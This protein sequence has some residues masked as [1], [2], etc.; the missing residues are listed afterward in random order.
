MMKTRFAL[1]LLTLSLVAFLALAPSRP[2]AAA[3]LAPGAGVLQA[4]APDVTVEVRRKH[5]SFR[6][7]RHGRRWHGL[8]G[9]PYRGRGIVAGRSP[10]GCYYNEGGGRYVSCSA[11]GFR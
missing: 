8:F 10:Y 7:Y 11:G 9:R 5:R 3:P 6:H 2:A 4:A 1:G